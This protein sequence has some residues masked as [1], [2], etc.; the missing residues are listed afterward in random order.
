M[1]R[2]GKFLPC[3]W[4]CKLIQ[5]P[6]KML[7]RFHK[8]SRNKT[9]IWLSN[10]TPRHI[11]WG[12]Q[13]WKRHMYPIVHWSTI[14]NSQNMEGIQMSINRWMGKKVVVH[15]HNGIL[16]SHKNECIWVSFDEVDE[17]RTYYMS[18]VRKEMGQSREMPL[19]EIITRASCSLLSIQ[20]DSELWEVVFSVSY[21]RKICLPQCHEEVWFHL[22]RN[23]ILWRLKVVL[24][25]QR[26]RTGR[27]LSPPQ[28]HQKNIS[29]LSK[30]YKTTSEC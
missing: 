29:T 9:T 12:N 20:E 28:I 13:N 27:P 11:P 3:W 4:E 14:Y 15:I 17:T 16:L 22:W 25:W 24:R 21:L 2:K 10:P 7:W 6:W 26:N 1:W 23:Q 5:P 19:P 18:E 8:K 30:F